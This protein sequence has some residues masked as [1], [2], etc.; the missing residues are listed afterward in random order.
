MTTPA[1]EMYGYSALGAALLWTKSTILRKKALGFGD[2]AEIL[3]PNSKNFQILIQFAAFVIIGALVGVG[4][5]SPGS[6]V[7]A[8]TGGLAWSRIISSD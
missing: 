5:A 8:I 1:L 6:P 2:I 4:V 3:F 7:Q